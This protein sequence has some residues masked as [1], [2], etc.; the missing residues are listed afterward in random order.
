MAIL[1]EVTVDGL[2]GRTGAVHYPLRNDINIFFGLN[3][4][5]KT[6]LLKILHSGLADNS[7][8][9]ARVAFKSARI[10]FRVGSGGREFERSISAGR[11]TRRKDIIGEREYRATM[12]RAIGMGL[13]PDDA[14]ELVH[15]RLEVGDWT[16]HPE[17]T[18]SRRFRH[19]YLS[20]N[21]LLT[22][23][24]PGRLG[25]SDMAETDLDV[26]FANQIKEVWRTYTN[27]VLS[28]VTRVQSGGLRDILRSLLFTAPEPTEQSPPEVQKAYQR[29]SHFLGLH[30]DPQASSVFQEFQ[31][32][33][34]EEPHF[35]GV[36]QDIDEIER[37]IE[38]AEEPRRKLANLVSNFFSEGKSIDF[39]NTGLQAKVDGTDIPVAS[40][41]SGEKQLVRILIEVI[42]TEDNVI[43]IDEPELSM[44]IDWQRNLVNAM[45]TVNPGVQIVMATHSPDIM[46]NV[47]D[48]CIFRL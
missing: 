18:D 19:G 8:Y 36:V 25:Y 29:A 43:I 38:L 48:D 4:S 9:L 24:A 41:S 42:T 16:T 26:I 27:R 47:P 23:V 13:S 34:N 6:S 7:S 30:P 12:E 46:E 40:L 5:G 44:H 10:R 14:A 17:N 32:R 1:T 22:P 37:R 3:G 35:R 39:S 11:K 2:A 15:N 31:R 21:R 33:F 28:E 20:T 45:R